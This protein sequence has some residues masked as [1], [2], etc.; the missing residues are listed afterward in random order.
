MLQ[1]KRARKSRRFRQNAT[2]IRN[3]AWTRARYGGCL[4]PPQASLIWT[5]SCVLALIIAILVAKFRHG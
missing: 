4:E 3:T 1:T 5:N 2:G